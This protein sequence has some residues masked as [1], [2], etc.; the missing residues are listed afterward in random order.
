MTDGSAVNTEIRRQ[1]LVE[2]VRTGNFSSQ[3]ELRKILL[4]HNFDVTQATLSR[5]LAKLGI[6]RV[7]TENG[8]FYRI[9]NRGESQDL[10]AL[11]R[12][13]IQDV[14]VN[15]NV[16]L[17]RT[18]PGRAQGVAWYLDAQDTELVLG[19]IAGDDVVVVYPKTDDKIYELSKYVHSLVNAP[20]FGE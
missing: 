3:E 12:L 5:D 8:A 9:V 6:V 13:E 11:V 20:E 2:L 18:L 17:V 19:T 10:L 15:D 16:V 4:Q 7:P 1:K 14:R